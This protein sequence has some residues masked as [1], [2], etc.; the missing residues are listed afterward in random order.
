MFFKKFHR[1]LEISE[2]PGIAILCTHTQGAWGCVRR[3]YFALSENS[4]SFDQTMV[5][6]HQVSSTKVYQW[7]SKEIRRSMT[8]EE[9]NLADEAGR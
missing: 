4:W 9:L 5:L 3:G 2:V 7:I 1:S 6:L 8:S